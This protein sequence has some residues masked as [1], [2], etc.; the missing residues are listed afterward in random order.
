MF[1]LISYYFLGWKEGGSNL[2]EDEKYSSSELLRF[3]T[4]ELDRAGANAV[5]TEINDGGRSNV[6]ED[7]AGKKTT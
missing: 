4:A 3:N 7:H 5:F 6:E 1:N 2:I